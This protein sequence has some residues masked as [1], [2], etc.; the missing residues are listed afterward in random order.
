MSTPTMI[1]KRQRLY[2]LALNV[3]TGDF[4]N[5]KISELAWVISQLDLAWGYKSKLDF[6]QACEAS[7][8]EKALLGLELN[9]AYACREDEA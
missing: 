9:E 2:E 6:M 8:N 7:G 4:K 5:I 3:S 1:E